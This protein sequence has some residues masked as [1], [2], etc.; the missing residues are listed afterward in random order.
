MHILSGLEELEA[1]RHFYES[2]CGTISEG[3]SSFLGEL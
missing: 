2:K 1:V 3:V